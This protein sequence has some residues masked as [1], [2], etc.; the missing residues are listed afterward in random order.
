MILILTSNDTWYLK[1]TAMYINSNSLFAINSH[2]SYICIVIR[3][4]IYYDNTNTYNNNKEGEE[5]KN[6]MYK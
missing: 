2:R 6:E 5:K 3:Q 4:N 1:Y